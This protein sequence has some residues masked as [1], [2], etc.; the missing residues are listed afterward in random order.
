MY[1]SLDFTLFLMYNIVIKG[2]EEQGDDE[3]GSN[4]ENS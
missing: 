3:K 2:T 4:K 1:F